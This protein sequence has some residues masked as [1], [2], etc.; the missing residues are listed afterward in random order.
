MNILI[1]A[2]DNIVIIDFGMATAFGLPRHG[3]W[4]FV[5]FVTYDIDTFLGGTPDYSPPE[6]NL[7]ATDKYDV[8]AIGCILFELL[9][10]Q[11]IFARRSE[12]CRYKKKTKKTSLRLPFL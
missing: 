3:K 1:T 10:G 6:E 7:L 2:E 12:S 4:L 9:S 8:F 5:C 11:L